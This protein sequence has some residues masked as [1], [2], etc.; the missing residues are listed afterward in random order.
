MNER[1]KEVFKITLGW[2]NVGFFCV[3]FY[4]YI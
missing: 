1:V 4:Q 2:L 3:K